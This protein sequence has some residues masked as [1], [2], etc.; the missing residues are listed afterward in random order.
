MQQ[1]KPAEQARLNQERVA[2]IQKYNLTNNLSYKI[3]RKTTKFFNFFRVALPRQN[4][5]LTN[6][7]QQHVIVILIYSC[8]DLQTLIHRPSPLH[9]RAT[10]LIVGHSYGPGTAAHGRC[11]LTSGSAARID[12]K[13]LT[14]TEWLDP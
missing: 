12:G 7:Q 5:P 1:A 10:K 11:H 6:N 8:H 13:S 3:M 9:W 4:S 2:K 14:M